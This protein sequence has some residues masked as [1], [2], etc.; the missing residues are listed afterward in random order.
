MLFCKVRLVRA[1]TKSRE[2]V[3]GTSR[4][5]SE[6]RRE[7]PYIEGCAISLEGKEENGMKQI[8]SCICGSR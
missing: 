6:K 4:I 8:M 5:R 3:D 2:I 7:H 1:W